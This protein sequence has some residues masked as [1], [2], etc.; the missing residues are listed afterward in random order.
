MTERNSKS[1]MDDRIWVP[2]WNQSKKLLKK[3]LVKVL[4]LAR[5]AD[6]AF[7]ATVL[8]EAKAAGISPDQTKTGAELATLAG[9]EVF[10]A[11]LTE[12]LPG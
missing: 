7:A 6:E 1:N 12:A 2:G 3:K 5:D 10:T 11:V 9:V 4:Y 8:A